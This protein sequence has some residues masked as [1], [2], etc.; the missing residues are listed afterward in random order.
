MNKKTQELISNLKGR[1]SKILTFSKRLTD[2][3]KIVLDGVYT[4][5]DEIILWNK[6]LTKN[7]VTRFKGILREYLKLLDDSN[8]VYVKKHISPILEK[9]VEGEW[10]DE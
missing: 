4:S 9:M 1:I 7:K 2:S 6:K 10:I 3:E 5:I 8:K